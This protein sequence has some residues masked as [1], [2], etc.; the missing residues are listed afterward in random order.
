MARLVWSHLRM[1]LRMHRTVWYIF[2]QLNG[3]RVPKLFS[4]VSFFF[5][6]FALPSY[7]TRTPIF[8]FSLCFFFCS[9]ASPCYEKNAIYSI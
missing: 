9:L 3:S 2:D 5:F 7:R 6:I 1:R 8:S 4:F